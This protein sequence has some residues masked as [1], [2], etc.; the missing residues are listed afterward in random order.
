MDVNDLEVIRENVRMLVWCAGWFSGY[1][2][3]QEIKDVFARS[4]FDS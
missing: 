3:W 2:L 4:L 1:L